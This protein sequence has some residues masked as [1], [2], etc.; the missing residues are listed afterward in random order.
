VQDIIL[1]MMFDA[2]V[3]YYSLSGLGKLAFWAITVLTAIN[4]VLDTANEMQKGKNKCTQ[5]TTN[6]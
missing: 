3:W 5:Q 2:V 4:I 6:R 1:Q